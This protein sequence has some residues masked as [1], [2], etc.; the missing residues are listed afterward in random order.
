MT[1]MAVASEPTGLVDPQPVA[2]R[3]PQTHAAAGLGLLAD[4]AVPPRAAPLTP[5]VVASTR[6]RCSRARRAASAGSR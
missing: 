5:G 3:S 1:V 2:P 4:V 6:R